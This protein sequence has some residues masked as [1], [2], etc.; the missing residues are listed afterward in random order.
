MSRTPSEFAMHI[1]LSGGS[2]QTV[3]MTQYKDINDIVQQVFMQPSTGNDY[4]NIPM[5]LEGE[6]M[7]VRPS[8]IAA[9]HVE[10]LFGSSL[11][12]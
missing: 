8:C 6:Y 12:Y 3:R 9:I 10:P 7:I 11:D 1:Y 4:I 2:E 5:P